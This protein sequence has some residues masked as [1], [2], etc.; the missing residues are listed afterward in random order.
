MTQRPDIPPCTQPHSSTQRGLCTIIIPSGPGD[1]STCADHLHHKEH[2]VR[3]RAARRCTIDGE[4]HWRHL[5]ESLVLQVKV[6]PEPGVQCLSGIEYLSLYW[7]SH[8]MGFPGGSDGKE[9]ACSV[10]DWGS[11]PGSGRSGEGNGYP[12]QY[13]CLENPMNRGA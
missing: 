1:S 9:S 7:T 13:S 8:A 2:L 6:S 11:I 12:L 4:D 5:S 3:S 10:R